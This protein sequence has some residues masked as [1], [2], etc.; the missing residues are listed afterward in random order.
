MLT[1][2]ALFLLLLLLA[3]LLL[4][5]LARQR[6]LLR[7][8]LD[9]ATGKTARRWNVEE[10]GEGGTDC[11]STLEDEGKREREE[12]EESSPPVS[13]KAGYRCALFT[14]CFWWEQRD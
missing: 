5:G 10:K 9:L 8:A 1:L 13:V 3:L 7:L 4:G 6:S 11:I 14:T 2:F 12:R